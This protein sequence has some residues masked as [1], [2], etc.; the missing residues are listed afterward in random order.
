MATPTQLE[1]ETQ[2]QKI[3]LAINEAR[4]F[5]SENT[6]NL[7]AMQDDII[8]NLESDHANDISALVRNARNSH[9]N[10]I[11]SLGAALDGHMRDWGRFVKSDFEEGSLA[12]LLTDIIR[13]WKDNSITIKSRAP[14][15]A[16][17]VAGGSN[18]GDGTVRRLTVNKDNF[19]IENMTPE[20]KTLRCIADHNSGAD[21]GKERFR[22]FGEGAGRD[23]LEVRGS[24]EEAGV[25]IN[26]QHSAFS[27]LR[28][29]SFDSLSGG[30]I[31]ALKGIPN[32]IVGTDIVN[33]EL[34]ETDLA[35]PAPNDNTTIRSLRIKA[36]ETLTQKLINIRQSLN[37]ALPFMLRIWFNKTPGA[38]TAGT[39]LIRLGSKF[40]SVNL[41]TAPANW[42]FL[43]M[44]IDQNLFF[45][46]FKEDSLDIR[47]EVTGLTGT[48]L[49]VDDVTFVP[50]TAQNGTFWILFPGRTPFQVEDVFTG[51]DSIAAD[52]VIQR[53][54][55]FRFGRFFPHQ[56]V[57]SIAD[58]T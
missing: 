49:L 9:R 19:V 6:K 5:G 17:V 41:A 22:L 16:T 25:E 29:S 39:L 23:L 18:V 54:L 35:L 53:S 34:D 43:E 45:E 3:A 46:N 58:P 21:K 57:P 56:A 44:A 28:N 47:I 50:W 51:T 55:V 2:L 7:V 11:L 31:S 36:N 24:G 10:T 40:V 14:S 52:S 26:A 48:Y 27:L 32:W 8:Q 1:L 12:L 13:H 15:F 33:F 37:P 4:K 20:L 38:V 42:N 30:S